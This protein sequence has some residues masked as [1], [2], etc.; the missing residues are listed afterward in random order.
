MR[1]SKVTHIWRVK[2]RKSILVVTAILTF[3]MIPTAY[4][5]I[6]IHPEN[7]HYF[8][9]S[10]SGKPIMITSYGTVAPSSYAIDYISD[11][12][13]LKAAGMP[14][15]RLWHFLPWEQ[16]NAIWPW[17]RSS[18]G[19][20]YMGGNKFNL[21][22]WDFMFWYRLRDSISRL[23]SSGIYAE[24]TFFE[25]CGMSKEGMMRW[26][27]NP[28]ASNNNINNLELPGG[29]YA[30]VPEF[31]NYFSK[32]NLRY[33]QERYIK[34]AIDET[35]Y[36]P[37]IIYEI[38]NEHLGDSDPIWVNYYSKLVK[39]YILNRY[40]GQQRLVSYSSLESDL[41]NCY[42][43]PNI[44]VV[45]KHFGTELDANPSI[46]NNYL[47]PRWKYNKAMNIDEF[48]NGLFDF[49]VLTKE[50]WTIV[51]SGGNFHIEGA[52]DTARPA[53]V[54][55][56][57]ESFKR[58]SEWNFIKA[59]PSKNLIVSGSGYCMAQQ[60][61]E[62]VSYFPFGGKK[63]ISIPGGKYRV[64][65]WNPR[66]GGFSGQTSV[67][68][69]GGWMTLYTPSADDWVLHVKSSDA[70][71]NLLPNITGP[72]PPNTS[73]GPVYY[74]VTF[75]RPVTGFNSASDLKIITSGTASANMVT[76][77]GSGAGP[78]KVTFSYLKGN[79]TIAIAV[80]GGAC[81]DSAGMTNAESQTSTALVV[82]NA[83]Y[84]LPG[85]PLPGYPL[86]GYP[87]PGY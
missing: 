82:T 23:S 55:A 37:N 25:R 47:E 42:T 24:F 84:P 17:T 22:N 60:G 81:M 67:S 41:E 1:G 43:N 48:A 31:Y 51:T 70:V 28:W 19:G 30:G 7:P 54:V 83:S 18:V 46:A 69:S 71:S 68:H 13:T 3:C 77:S 29:A 16:N 79:G 59:K 8:I 27:N 14:Y 58:L 26:G 78:Y 56:N 35:I 44:D 11:I 62:Y 73:A 15:V 2:L 75:N 38:E 40:P 65:W 49:R 36:Y 50:C 45:N 6:R 85:Y 52:D 4:A 34:K 53:S 86:P 21:N 80:R 57:I 5:D 61:V 87:L 10:V 74:Y 76:V 33:Q 64:Q 66:S 20:A 32:P 72:T 12:S 9:D 63:I 39:D